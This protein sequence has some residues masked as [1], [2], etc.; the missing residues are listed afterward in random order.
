[1]TT[2]DW[3][4]LASTVGFM[5]L[6]ILMAGSCYLA[7]QVAGLPVR[8]RQALICLGSLGPIFALVSAIALLARPPFMVISPGTVVTLNG[9][10]IWT[11]FIAAIIGVLRQENR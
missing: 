2:S 1:M 6:A 9:I 11:V 7:V 5:G 10:V 3:A 8:I 4:S